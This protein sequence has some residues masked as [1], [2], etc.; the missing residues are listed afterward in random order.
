MPALLCSYIYI[1]NART[2]SCAIHYAL[3]NCIVRY[4][5]TRSI[6]IK[7]V[8]MHDFQLTCRIQQPKQDQLRSRQHAQREHPHRQCLWR[9]KP[10]CLILQMQ[11]R[12][13][14]LSIHFPGIKRKSIVHLRSI[15]ADSTRCCTREKNITAVPAT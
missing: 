9:R 5:S 7:I 6:P 12:S 1:W 14:R 3:V 8:K 4:L 11:L 13:R 15:R 2:T 10:P